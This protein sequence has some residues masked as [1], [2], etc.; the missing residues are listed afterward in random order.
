VTL[1]LNA[2]AIYLGQG[3]GAGI[4]ALVLLYGSPASLE[5]VAALYVSVESSELIPKCFAVRS[6]PRTLLDDTTFAT[7]RVLVLADSTVS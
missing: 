5:W 7:S 6:S 3:D 4:G 2:S 1:S